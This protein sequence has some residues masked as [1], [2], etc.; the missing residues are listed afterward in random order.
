ME[1][2]EETNSLIQQLLHE[3]RKLNQK[4]LNLT[5]DI[6]K[7]YEIMRAMAINDGAISRGDF[8]AELTH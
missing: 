4:V 2:I 3:N 6:A 8:P 5:E 7:L 1:E